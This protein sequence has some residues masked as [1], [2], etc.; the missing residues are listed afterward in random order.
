[1][2][3]VTWAKPLP[4]QQGQHVFPEGVLCN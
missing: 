3:D 1:M 4:L 2:D